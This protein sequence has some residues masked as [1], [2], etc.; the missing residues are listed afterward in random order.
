MIRPEFR[1]SD[2]L[3]DDSRTTPVTECLALAVVLDGNAAETWWVLRLDAPP[4]A[5]HGCACRFCAPH[6]Q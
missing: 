5:D 4:N 6:E 3:T 2:G 1:R